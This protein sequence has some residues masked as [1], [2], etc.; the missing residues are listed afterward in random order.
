MRFTAAFASVV[1]I[2]SAAGACSGGDEKKPSDPG[3][4]TKAPAPTASA[5]TS[6]SGLPGLTKEGWFGIGVKLHAR[7]EIKNVERRQDRSVLH[8]TVTSLDDRP[9]IPQNAFGHALGDFRAYRIPLV[10]PVGRKIYHPLVNASRDTLGSVQGR[11]LPGVVYEAVVYYPPIPEGVEVVTA[12]TAGTAGEFTGVPVTDDPAP[13]PAPVAP[14]EAPAGTVASWPLRDDPDARPVVQ[15]LYDITEGPVEETTSSGVEQKVGLRTDVLFAFN[16]DKL[17]GK[18]KAVLDE[19]A[20]ETKAKA[21]PA[22]PPIRVIGH[23]DSKGTD[24]F[25]R[26]LSLRRA[27]TVERELRARLGGAY[28]YVSEGKGESEPIAQEGG[29]TDAAARSRN[30]R[31]EVSYQIKQETPGTTVTTTASAQTGGIGR[32]APFNADDGQIVASRFARFREQKRRIDVHPFYRDG[33]Y[34]VAVFDIQSLGAGGLPAAADYTHIDYLGG[35]FTAFSVIDPR[36]QDVYRAVRMGPDQRG[37]D[38]YVDPGWATFR[39]AEGEPNR[40]FFY[41]PAPPDD[42]KV[43]TF[44]GGPFG[45][46]LEVPIRD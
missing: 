33:A 11:Y 28:K 3:D 17:S 8:F 32:P 22:K 23:T 36:T 25:N 41:V 20:E 27:Q 44:D 26:K 38:E 30:R 39:Q 42:V 29:P 46:V 2:A 31:V 43:V 40:G 10:D 12:L 9:V 24:P 16:S 5:S 1:L 18:A 7:V 4:R 13:P 21:D 37:P 35:E 14:Q 6:A 19:V 15:N 34:L 45:K